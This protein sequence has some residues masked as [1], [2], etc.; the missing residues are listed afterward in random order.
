LLGLRGW[1]DF[2]VQDAAGNTFC[3]ATVPA[4]PQY[5]E[6]YPEPDLQAALNA[7]SRFGGRIKWYVKP[8]VFGGDSAPGPN[9]NWVDHQQHAQLIKW[10]NDQYRS[11]RENKT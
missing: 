11:Q 5:L 1:D 9:L 2:I 3:V 4:D 8:V 6:P 7:D 10:W